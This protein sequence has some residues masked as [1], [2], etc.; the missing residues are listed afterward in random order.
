MLPF[1]IIKGKNEFQTFI[2]ISV[3]LG[4]LGYFLA[5]QENNYRDFFQA[6]YMA[7][8]LL[9]DVLVQYKNNKYHISL[10]HNVW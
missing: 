9:F 4:G 6:S 3:F 5:S 1:L 2:F 10:L 7:D 8:Y